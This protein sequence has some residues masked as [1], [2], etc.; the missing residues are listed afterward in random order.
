MKP[1]QNVQAGM[2]KSK[3]ANANAQRESL[4]R[5]D[6]AEQDFLNQSNEV[7]S[8]LKTAEKGFIGLD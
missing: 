2:D 3:S 7:M 5:L 8:Y 4:I 1:I 6:G